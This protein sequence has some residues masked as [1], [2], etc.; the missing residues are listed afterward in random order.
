MIATTPGALVRY[1]EREW[2]V[3]P[4]D[5]PNLVLLRPIGGSAREVCGVVKP[6]A[7]LMAYEI[8]HE[9]I[10]PALFPL[11][12]PED[13]Q[14]HA[15][16][17]LLL[18]SAR[19][20]L[21]DGAAPFR[22][23]G[24]LSVRPRP[25][26]FVPLVMA[27]RL[28]TVR[29]LIAD[30]VGVGKTIEAALI[31]RE[32]LDRGTVRRVAVL[33]PPYLCEQWQRELAEKFHIE[34]V[35]IRAGTVARL[36]R[37]TPQDRSIFAHFRHF[38]ASIDTVKGDRYRAAFL[39][40]C[41]DL[42]LVDE[43]HGAAQPPAGR[44][45]GQQQ[46]HAL[47]VEIA[48]KHDRSLILLSATPHSGVES[49]FQSLLGLLR[50]DFRFLSLSAL[51]EGQT[52]LLARHFVQRRRADVQHWM[53]EDTPF[54]KRDPAGAEQPYRFSP[55]YRRFYE[56]VYEFAGEMV[57]SAE[58]LTGW[59]QR[60]RFWS[61][62]ALLRCVSSS[63]AAA[64]VALFKRAG[65]DGDAGDET[66]LDG[67][68]AA[69]V[70]A[71]FTPLVYDP[72]EAEAANDAP[73]SAVFDAQ[74][75]D[76]GW[77][78][79]D[80]GR[81]RK[82]AR[83]AAEL[84]GRDDAKLQKLIE[85]VRE[86]LTAGYQPIV[87]CRYIATADYVT[88]ELGRS[89][90]VRFPSARIVAIT[91][92][93]AEDERRLKI[94]SLAAA[95]VRVLVATDCLS[96]GINL[97]EQFSAVVHYDLPWN[98][99]RLEQREGRVDRFGQKVPVVKAIMIFGQDNP[100]DGA[101]LDVLL[102]KARDIYRE[103]GVHVPVPMDS[104]TVMEA[105]L[106]SLFERTTRYDGQ[107]TLFDQSDEAGRLVSRVHDE[108]TRAADRER[109]SRTR[110]AQRAIRPD[111]VQRALGETDAVLG[112]PED[113]RRFLV[114]A[115]Q[116]LPFGLS[117]RPGGRYDL[118]TGDLP[119]AVRL[120]LGS[121]PSTW[122]ITFR[123]PAPEHLAYVGRN[124]PLVEGLAEHLLDLAFHPAGPDQPAAR[125]GVI[126][127]GQ[128]S[129]RT[130]LFLLRLRYLHIEGDEAAATLAEETL[131]WGVQ[132][133]YPDAS[134]LEPAEALHLLDGQ[135]DAVSVPAAERQE[136]LRETLGWWPCLEG[137]LAKLLS[138]RAARLAEE[139]GRLADMVGSAA[140]LMQIEPQMPPDLL[141]LVVLL[142][143]VSSGVSR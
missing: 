4:S 133:I 55:A 64:Q 53:G 105:V 143:V 117:E 111:E 73:P 93:L 37:Q 45:A 52:T 118:Q 107:M 30:D 2:V 82:F 42:V 68:E 76:P 94:E 13:V 113:V 9:R 58:T 112:G 11:P 115:G 61:A 16:V 65:G 33:C 50:P 32:L 34:A 138:E 41:P 137:P 72:T 28:P 70:D 6:L 127:T 128:V 86:L 8:P 27:L 48:K 66:G 3:L 19:L 24:H 90:A 14:D 1:R 81:L 124:H 78:V 114:Q 95:P 77:A 15:A 108:W 121:V 142:P 62:L 12:S 141:G 101:V 25:Y 102:R 43:A 56:A 79:S 119:E 99:N 47:L 96:E 29:L 122:P 131:T 123:S 135:L 51:S 116:R 98:P 89:L 106:H 125:C 18:E 35:V 75:R 84:R 5:D 83:L 26:Q 49:S 130:A 120:R 87:W 92:A 20:L 74:E 23:L 110:F 17:R 134:E 22:S 46:R 129:R 44:A 136:V 10:E 126:R 59:K 36:E 71:E 139:H 97:Q 21:R 40:H 85:V 109:E 140:K 104:E 7:D 39:Q 60:M 38:V 100:V 69:S 88:E 80:Q 31:A 132:G 57:R 54:P 103:L 91:G 63:P 67:W